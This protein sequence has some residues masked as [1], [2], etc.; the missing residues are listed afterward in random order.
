MFPLEIFLVRHGES[1]GNIANSRSRKDD[2]SDFSPEFMN[3]HST[4]LRLTHKGKA[5]A[6]VVGDWLR[7]NNLAEFDSFYVSPYARALETAACL[8]L[9]NAM[10]NV[11]FR[12]RERDNGSLEITPTDI[13]QERLAKYLDVRPY[14]HFY[15]PMPDGESICDVCNRLRSLVDVLDSEHKQK[16]GIIVAHGDVMKA[17]RVIFEGIL[18]DRYQE[19]I[20][21]NSRE[22]KIGNGQIIHYTRVDPDDSEHILSDRFGWVR[23]INPWK[24]EYAGHDWRA[25][26]PQFYSNEDLLALAERSKRLLAE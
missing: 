12:L 15:T 22:F 1:E 7:E 10:W 17:L 13:R 18:P 19:L 6:T 4:N 23:S 3:R 25:I 11:D 20:E 8:G 26:E 2:H 14:H 5:Q 21:Q 16:R 9:H 24:P